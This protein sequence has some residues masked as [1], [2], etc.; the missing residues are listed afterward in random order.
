MN[1]KFVSVGKCEVYENIDEVPYK[2]TG[3][4]EDLS[5]RR[6]AGDIV[7]RAELDNQPEFEGFLGPMWDGGMLRYETA[8]MYDRLSR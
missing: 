2:L 8:E 7:H 6:A 1:M 5:E 3:Y 4:T